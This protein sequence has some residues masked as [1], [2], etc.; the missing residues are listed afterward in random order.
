MSKL[1]AYLSI[2]DD[3]QGLFTEDAAITLFNK[4]E[5]VAYC[6]G[7]TLDTGAKI[8]DRPNPQ[9][10]VIEAMTSGR[11]VLRK[12]PREVFGVPFVG[13]ACPIIEE[14]YITGC[15]AVATSIER[16]ETLVNAGNAILNFA[17]KI[18]DIAQNFS[19]GAE[20]LAST[21]Q[22]LNQE[23]TQVHSEMNQ[24]SVVTGKIKKISM[25]SK[26]LGLNAAIEASKAGKH[27]RGFSVVAEEVRKLADNT[28]ESTKEIETNVKQVQLSVNNL[29]EAIQELGH[30]AE[31]QAM[32][33][34]EIADA[35]KQIEKMASDLVKAGEYKH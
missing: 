4:H 27:G 35:L 6:P 28:N 21:V 15:I 13:V 33:A 32:G 18:A 2:W 14:G 31:T 12:V 3:L 24:T 8:G 1:D 22:N 20:E 16:Y 25:R 23:T 19:A 11:R 9:S 7:Y 5:I 30:I 29:I 10:N 34:V 17:H 26:I